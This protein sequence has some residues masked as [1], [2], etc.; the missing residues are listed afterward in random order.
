MD[1]KHNLYDMQQRNLKKEHEMRH[2]TELDF[3]K[4]RFNQKLQLVKDKIEQDN[5]QMIE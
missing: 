4:S 5:N 1:Q 3:L 2:E